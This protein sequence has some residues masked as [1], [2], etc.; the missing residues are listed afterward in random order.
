MRLAEADGLFGGPDAVG[1]EAQGVVGEGGGDGA[2]DFEFV[3]GMEDAGLHFVGGEAEALLEGAG[4]ATTWSMVRTSP[5]P[6]C[7]I[8]VAEETVG[9]EGDAVAQAAAEDVADRDAPGLAE[10]VEAGE[11]E[12]GEDLGAVVV[13]RRGR[14]GDQEAHLFEAR[15]VVADEVRSS[16]RGRPLRPIR[17]RRPFRRGR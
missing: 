14:V 17:R 4:V 5:S 9:R 6:V 16:W 1:V 7:G 10:D 12:R 15:G 13:E 8:R 2:I 11:F 3:V